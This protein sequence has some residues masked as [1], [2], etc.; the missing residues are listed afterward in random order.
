MGR[1][2][3]SSLTPQIHVPLTI[4][5]TMRLCG[6]GVASRTTQLAVEDV[7]RIYGDESA[8]RYEAK[9]T[10]EKGARWSPQ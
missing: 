3:N 2:R 7:A 6:M 8:K 4:R 10:A 1:R 5:E 9:L